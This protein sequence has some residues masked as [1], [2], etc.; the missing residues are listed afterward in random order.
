LQQRETEL[1]LAIEAA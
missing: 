1:K